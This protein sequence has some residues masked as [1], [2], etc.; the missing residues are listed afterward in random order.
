M[1]SPLRGQACLY[2][3]T[4]IQSR[5]LTQYTKH[6]FYHRPNLH[7]QTSFPNTSAS[8]VAQVRLSSFELQ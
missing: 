3:V 4:E 6:K 7:I 1:R 2:I 5:L 8:L